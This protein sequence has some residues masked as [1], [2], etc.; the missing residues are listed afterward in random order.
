MKRS[1][2]LGAM[3]FQLFLHSEH[4]NKQMSE[5]ENLAFGFSFIKGS[6]HP[7]KRP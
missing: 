1:G 5:I 6:F 7:R 3:C 2:D 4:A